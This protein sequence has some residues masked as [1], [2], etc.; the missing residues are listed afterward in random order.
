MCLA[1]S[2]AGTPVCMHNATIKE[3]LSLE[4]ASTAGFFFFS[5]WLA[6]SQFLSISVSLGFW[7]SPL[8]GFISFPL[9]SEVSLCIPLGFL[10]CISL[11]AVVAVETLHAPCAAWTAFHPLL[12]A[13]VPL[14]CH[15]VARYSPKNSPEELFFPLNS[16]TQSVA[17]SQ[18]KLTH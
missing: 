15:I 14:K 8:L 4:S 1:K 12:T 17:N 13:I 6:S 16:L 7:S 9:W 11:S 3:S 2:K 10:V 18:S 5:L